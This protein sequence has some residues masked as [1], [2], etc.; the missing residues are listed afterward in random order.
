MKRIKGQLLTGEKLE[1][2]D[3]Q[4]Y[5]KS[6]KITKFN[7]EIIYNIKRAE[8]RDGLDSLII[9]NSDILVKDCLSVE[10]FSL[11]KEHIILVINKAR[12]YILAEYL[13]D[14]ESLSIIDVSTKPFRFS[15][16]KVG[17]YFSDGY[18]KR[19]FLNDNY[20][21]TKIVSAIKLLNKDTVIIGRNS[22]RK[23]LEL[24]YNRKLK[25]D[26]IFIGFM[27]IPLT[28][29]ISLLLDLYFDNLIISNL[30]LIVGLFFTLFFLIISKKYY[31]REK[32]LVKSRSHYRSALQVNKRK[33]LLFKAKNELIM[34]KMH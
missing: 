30:I 25:K 31:D 17:V 9:N 12:E 23:A 28:L 26:Y 24:V 18:R 5:L 27:F 15:K 19:L 1:A 33:E 13:K 21:D 7:T 20:V 11:F 16:Q 34:Q 29:M 10:A 2:L 32:V 14:L 3:F 6:E 8:S 22:A 4:D